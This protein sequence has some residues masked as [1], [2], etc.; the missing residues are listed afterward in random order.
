MNN[1]LYQYMKNNSY[2]LYLFSDPFNYAI[3]G[4]IVGLIGQI[5]ESDLLSFLSFT[6]RAVGTFILACVII[7]LITKINK[8]KSC[9]QNTTTS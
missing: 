4:I 9:K 2:Q 8:L 5:W 6:L 1:Q 7:S 3:I